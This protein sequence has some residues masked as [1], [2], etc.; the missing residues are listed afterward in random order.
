MIE[1]A[2]QSNPNEH[3]EIYAKLNQQDVGQ[4]YAGYQWWNLQQ[5][6]VS[7]QQQ[8]D[9]LHR[10]IAANAEL[11]EMVHPPAIALATIARLQA[12]GVND[13]NLLD[14][15]LERGEDWLDRT[16]QRLDYCEQLDFIIDDY[17]QWCQNA[18]D[19]AYDWIDSMREDGTSSPTEV[20]MDDTSTEAT[21]ELLLQKLTSEEEELLSPVSQVSQPVESSPISNSPIEETTAPEKSEPSIDEASVSEQLISQVYIE[22]DP[23]PEELPPVEGDDGSDFEQFS[24]QKHPEDTLADESPIHGE[25]S[26]PYR[27]YPAD[28]QPGIEADGPGKAEQSRVP[29]RRRNFLQRLVGKIWHR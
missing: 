5:R 25:E 26:P 10:E 18:L 4:F 19:G 15:M 7:L 12:S 1:T 17:T 3:S 11:L 14:R 20:P 21:E 8:I 2:R 9:T 16:M 23:G 13:I 24:M 28:K 6:S 22:F 27:I 29:E